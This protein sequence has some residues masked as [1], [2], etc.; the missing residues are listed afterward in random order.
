[1]K[2]T[3]IHHKFKGTFKEIEMKDFRSSSSSIT[4]E[5]SLIESE[6]GL[7]EAYNSGKMMPTDDERKR[8]ILYSK[9]DNMNRNLYGGY[10]NLDSDII[11]PLWN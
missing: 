10:D 7:S 4:S 1:M 2:D 8:A 6:P 3:G 11:K 5:I 9:H